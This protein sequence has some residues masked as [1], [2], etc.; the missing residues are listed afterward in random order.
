MVRRDV[1]ADMEKM[2]KLI[3][4]MSASITTATQ[5]MVEKVQAMELANTAQ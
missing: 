1:Q 5:D 3:K 4:D 2:V